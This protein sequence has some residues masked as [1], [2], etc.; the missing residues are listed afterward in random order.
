MRALS[1]RVRS[2]SHYV[3]ILSPSALI[4]LRPL[5]AHGIHCRFEYAR[6]SLVNP[7]SAVD[8]AGGNGQL[9]LFQRQPVGHAGSGQTDPARRLYPQL[10]SFLSGVRRRNRRHGAV[11]RFLELAGLAL[12]RR[13]RLRLDLGDRGKRAV[14]QRQ[15]QQPWPAAGGLYDR[16]LP[17]YGDRPIVVEHDLDGIAARGAVG[18]RHRDQRDVA[19]AVCAGQPP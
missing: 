3:R 17:R 13:R 1:L 15:S 4:A 8:L 14:A 19:D 9:L 12:L 7:C 6:A 18:D 10:S 16:L 2:Q 5:A 11:D